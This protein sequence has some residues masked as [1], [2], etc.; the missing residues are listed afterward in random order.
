MESFYAKMV[1]AGV[2]ADG[3]DI[4]S[5]YTLDYVNQG[6]GLDLKK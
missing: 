4:K 6:L 2:I 3:I 5:S 1:K